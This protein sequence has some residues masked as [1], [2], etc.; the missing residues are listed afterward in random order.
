MQ[1]YVDGRD[2]Y[3]T[4]D[5]GNLILP[6]LICK[7]GFAVPVSKGKH[8]VA[9][10]VQS[11]SGGWLLAS[12][13]AFS[14]KGPD[15]MKDFFQPWI[16]IFP[17]ERMPTA[18]PED[19]TVQPAPP[20]VGTEVQ[21]LMERVKAP[22]RFAGCKPKFAIRPED[23]AYELSSRRQ[24][25][26]KACRYAVYDGERIIGDFARHFVAGLRVDYCEF[27]PT[28]SWKLVADNGTKPTASR[29]DGRL[30]VG[31]PLDLQQPAE[32]HWGWAVTEG[33]RSASVRQ[34]WTPK[35]QA[36]HPWRL[37][38]VTS[39]FRVDPVCGYVV[40]SNSVYVADRPPLYL[41]TGKAEAATSSRDGS[42]ATAAR[43]AQETGTEYC[44]V[45]PSHLSFHCTRGAFD[46]RYERT[47][48]TPRGTDKYVGWIN[49][50]WQAQSSD[51]HGLYFRPDGFVGF[52]VDPLGWGQ[53]HSFISPNREVGFNNATCWL[54]QDQHCGTAV[55]KPT[56]TDGRYRLRIQYR[57]HLLP[58]E[59]MRHILD[60]MELMPMR[61]E[62]LTIHQD[63]TQYFESDSRQEAAASPWTAGVQIADGQGRSGKR[64]VVLRNAGDGRRGPTRPRR[65]S[66]RIDAQ[67]PMAPGATY[68][69][70]AWVKAEGAGS[71]VSLAAQPIANHARPSADADWKPVVSAAVTPGGEWRQVE[72][73]FT[74]PPY[75][76][77]APR[78]F[79]QTEVAPGGAVY[80]DDV[81]IAKK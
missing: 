69:L 11:G 29:R 9:A 53:A 57:L 56:L 60:R 66:L 1:W 76:G 22:A 48:Y 15:A 65:A 51:D 72:L 31:G 3:S 23:Q 73:T 40:D 68:R 24:E 17:E 7:R 34:W 36:T 50:T 43:D 59:V 81:S 14:T 67:P 28:G 25:F 35:P 80:V 2:V 55:R 37:Y 30:L 54:L 13:G 18:M 64:S 38:E 32:P 20:I 41:W 63:E 44:N 21:R 6:E 33:G 19:K 5:G 27:F 39:T 47:F 61:D 10:L 70:E 4:M 42:T 79:L 49:D 75:H 71:S 52:A 58:P 77:F 62:V 74:T 26:V 16:T 8:V 78:L 46:W 12:R 45:L